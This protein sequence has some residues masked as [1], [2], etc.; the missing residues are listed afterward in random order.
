MARLRQITPEQV[1]SVAQRWFGDE[2][3]TTGVLWPDAQKRAA[4]AAAPKPTPT[5]P[6]SRH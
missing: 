1:Q 2:Q 4:K 3:L 6:L 5:A